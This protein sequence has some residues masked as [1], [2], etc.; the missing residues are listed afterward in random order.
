GPITALQVLYLIKKKGRSLSKLASGIKLYPQVL[1]NVD[2]EKKKDI[3]AIPEIEAAIKKA[4]EKLAAKGRILVRPSGT[5]PKI[6]VMVE[7]KDKG[8]IEKI[9]RDI[10]KVIKDKMSET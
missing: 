7:G 10:A 6:R 2:V 3:K 9:A 5:E 1:V 8:L 4:E